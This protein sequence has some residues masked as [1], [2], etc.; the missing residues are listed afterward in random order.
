M[1][2]VIGACERCGADKTERHHKD[3]NTLNNVS[4]NI[5][6]LCRRCHM[7]A[8]GRLSEAT[9]KMK[10]LRVIGVQVAAEKKRA[11]THC[12]RGHELF[13][14]NLYVNRRGLRIC[15]ECRKIHKADHH[16]RQAV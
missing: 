5:A 11:M 2:P 16:A 4:S 9:E 15:K 3:G 1:Y 6:V 14:A 12:K 8:D 7:D 10:T 13:G